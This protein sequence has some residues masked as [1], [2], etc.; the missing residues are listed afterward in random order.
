MSLESEW[1]LR[2][3]PSAL[4]GGRR[5]ESM[6]SNVVFPDPLGPLIRFRAPGAKWHV[7]RVVRSSLFP[8]R[9]DNSCNWIVGFS[10]NCLIKLLP[11]RRS[12]ARPLD[13]APRRELHDL[14]SPRIG[15]TA[16]EWRIRDRRQPMVH[17]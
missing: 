15:W 11:P 9:I 12:V 7:R 17:P 2:T 14:A 8:T 16:L 3:I 13:G 5:I 1:P 4:L 10:G 6:S